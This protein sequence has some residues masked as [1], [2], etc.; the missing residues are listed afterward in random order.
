M[1]PILEHV[2]DHLVKFTLIPHVVGDGEAMAVQVTLTHVVA[3]LVFQADMDPALLSVSGRVPVLVSTEHRAAVAEFFMRI[4]SGLRV[5][6][7]LLDYQD[8]EACFRLEVEADVAGL[9]D[10]RISRYV[11]LGMRMV[12]GYFPALMNVIYRG[13]NPMQAVEQSEAEFAALTSQGPAEGREA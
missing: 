13:T 4:N 11:L 5:G 8:G 6:R 12:D 3:T 2:R 1:N 9:T 10:E 7:F